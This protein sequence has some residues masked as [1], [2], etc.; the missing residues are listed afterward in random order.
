M[1][2]MILDNKC[3][4]VHAR[5]GRG[6]TAALLGGLVLALT[7]PGTGLRAQVPDISKAALLSWPE[8]TEEQIVVGA[9]NLVPGAVWTP[10]PEPIFKRFGQMC[11]TVPTT[12]SQQ[13]FKLMPGRQFSD[14]FSEKWGPFTNRNSYKDWFKDPGEAWIVTNGV[15]QLT[16]ITD[17]ILVLAPLGTNAAAYLGDFYVSVDL[18][19][20]VSGG[21][22]SSAFWLGGRCEKLG[23][24]YGV[25]YFGGLTLNADGIPGRSG[26]WI[27]NNDTI[28]LGPHFDMQQNPLPYRIQFS[29]VGT[30][31]SLRLLN[32]TN[33][34]LIQEVNAND[35][36]L[37][38]GWVALGIEGWPGLVYRFTFTVDNFLAT[39][40]KP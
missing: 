27:N 13:F 10:W 38:N 39:G 26:L 3:K 20:W 11:M 33:G 24:Y 25:G 4:P 19:D 2:T 1:K 9:T 12:A 28:T 34:Q 5:G 18:L 8:P 30:N 36:T 37:T 7:L 29:G 32:L 17:S 6:R 22:N 23:D 40:T 31:L 15:L 16:G 14:D 21:T 35:S